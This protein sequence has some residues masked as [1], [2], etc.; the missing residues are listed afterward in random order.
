MKS[1]E[2]LREE[3]ARQILELALADSNAQFKLD[4]FKA[5]AKPPD[6]KPTAEIPANDAMSIFQARVRRAA[7]AKDG[8]D[9]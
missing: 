5:T 4:S 7:E 3:L 1:I 8:A 2:E 9:E 6:R